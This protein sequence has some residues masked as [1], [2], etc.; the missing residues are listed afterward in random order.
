MPD[1]FESCRMSDCRHRLV[2]DPSPS[3]VIEYITRSDQGDSERLRK[4]LQMLE[5]SAVVAMQMERR[6]QT[7]A[8][9]EKI[10]IAL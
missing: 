7:A 10:A 6:S 2:Q 9:T 5:F 4:S 8:A 3:R 1:I